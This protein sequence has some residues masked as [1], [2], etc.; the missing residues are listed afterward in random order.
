VSIFSIIAVLITIVAI[1]S[2]INYRYIKLPTTV[3]LMVIALGLSL[4]LVGLGA[5]GVDIETPAQ[6][7]LGQIDFGEALMKGML[8]FLLFAGALKID[9][10]DL[11]EQKY[12]IGTLATGG[13]IASTFIIG[14]A[15]YL[16]TNLLDLALPYIYCLVFGALISPTDPVAVLSILKSVKAPKT[17]ETKIAGESLFN[18]GVGVVVF[19]VLVGIAVGGSGHSPTSIG[20]VIVLFAEEAIGGVAFGLAIGWVAYRIIKDVDT[21][22][23]EILVTLA[24]VMGGYALAHSIHTSGPIAIVVAG[25]LIGNHGRR[26][27]MSETT[28]DHLDKFWELIDEILN[29]VL[30]VLIGL[31]ILILAFTWNYLVLGLVAIPVV[32]GARFASVWTAI[33]LLEFR[34]EFSRNATAILTWG[35]LRGGISIA[36]ALSL[37]SGATRDM[38]VAITYVVVVFSI[39]V[40]GLTINKLVRR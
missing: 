15:I 5:V 10:N 34:R 39:L 22:T 35:G 4:G 3:G 18:D 37:A 29:A 1:A 24:L 32:L 40:Q 27:G 36:L 38:I 30:F 17:L 31:E 13:V 2:Y 25:L 9:L 14:T 8:S 20:S 6:E 26:F 33:N 23:V 12:I 21:Y 11:A 28:R 16:A 7:F 19:T